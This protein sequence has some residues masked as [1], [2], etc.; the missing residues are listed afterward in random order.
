MN[1]K[2]IHLLI[3]KEYRVWC[4]PNKVPD[5]LSVTNQ[6][7]KCTCANCLT[8]MRSKTKDFHRP[9]RV[10]HVAFTRKQYDE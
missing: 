7:G 1:Q 3:P 5:N 9:F 8:I 2:L 10:A 4:L 6:P